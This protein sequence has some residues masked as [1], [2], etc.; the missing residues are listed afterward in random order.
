[1]LSVPYFT[2]QADPTR[3]GTGLGP[4]SHA[5][6]FL[7]DERTWDSLHTPSQRRIQALTEAEEEAE[8]IKRKKSSKPMLVFCFEKPPDLTFGFCKSTIRIPSF[9]KSIDCLP[10]VVPQ[11]RDAVMNKALSQ[12]WVS[13]QSSKREAV[14]GFSDR[15]AGAGQ[16][17]GPTF[18]LCNRPYSSG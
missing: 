13:A 18:Q 2:S 15:R 3:K 6:G 4:L 12:S 17:G 10:T 1:M 7:H 9:L 14:S 8:N 16:H 5:A 11:T